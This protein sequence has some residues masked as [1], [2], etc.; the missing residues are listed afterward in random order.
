MPPT[1]FNDGPVQLE[2][3][4]T[5]GRKFKIDSLEKHIRI[6][7]KVFNQ[8]RKQ[9][10]MKDQ[11]KTDE[12]I[13]MESQGGKMN[14]FT[15]PFKVRKGRVGASTAAPETEAKPPAKIPKWKQQ[16]MQFRQA[17]AASAAVDDAG[18][19]GFGTKNFRP[20]QMPSAANE[21][22]DDRIQCKWCGRKFNEQAGT[23]H[24][25]HCEQKHKQNL[26]K[27]GGKAG[28]AKRGTQ[29]GF[30]KKY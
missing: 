26:I 11:R 14:E 18:G 30:T 7:D 5:C 13:Q 27:N 19:T 1:M 28:A 21:I 25:P 17:M 3:C 12:L 23:R 29:V 22:D 2:P 10:N 9:F 8:K 24:M 15:K 20:T 4:P 16:S 6:C